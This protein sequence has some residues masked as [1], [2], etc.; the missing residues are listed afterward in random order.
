MNRAAI[1]VR[2]ERVAAIDDELRGEIER[3]TDAQFGHIRYVWAPSE[4][5]AI[6]RVDGRLAGTLTLVT[7]EVAAG[8][9]RVRVAGIGNV[10]TKPECRLRGVA[11]A[12]MRAASDLMRTTLEVEFGMLICLRE[13]APVYEKA[14]WIRVEGPT[15]FSQPKGRAT[16]P[17][18]TMILKLT[19]R[20][21]PD[22]P[23]DL[24]GLPW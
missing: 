7:R 10:V 19:A 1:D 3:W 23:I 8:R 18:D 12:M 6:A 15:E 5:Y 9:E 24:C 21:W 14:G 2:I 11:S 20:A 17:H 13:V 16:Y 4:W 22:G